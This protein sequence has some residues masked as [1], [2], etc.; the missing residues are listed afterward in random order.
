MA[1]IVT[2]LVVKTGHITG[3]G[4]SVKQWIGIATCNGVSEVPWYASIK[5]AQ[6]PPING[7]VTGAVSEGAG[8][9]VGEA[10]RVGDR[11]T[12]LGG[13]G[14]VLVTSIDGSIRVHAVGV[15]VTGVVVKTIYITGDGGSVK[16]WIGIAHLQRCKRSSVVRQH[17]RRPG[18]HPS[19]D[20][21]RCKRPGC[22][23]RC[24]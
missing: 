11:I 18:L 3:D 4:G 7:I 21:Y 13:S 9:G 17:Q 24:W 1:V 22:R 12:H 14:P 15:I 19:T 2:G 6:V 8:A 23:C 5:G 20:R 16:Q 10:D